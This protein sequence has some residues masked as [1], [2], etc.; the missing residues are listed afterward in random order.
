LV[1]LRTVSPLLHGS[2]IA[3]LNP[4]LAKTPS[5]PTTS[6]RA[7]DELEALHAALDSRMAALEAAL[8]DPGECALEGL[9]L[10]LARTAAEEAEAIARRASAQ[11][12][13]E[14]NKQ[15][16]TALSQAQVAEAALTAERAAGLELHR[17]LGAARSELEASKQK[18]AALTNDLDRMNGAFNNERTTLR[19]ELSEVE[20]CFAAADTLRQQAEEARHEDV[21]RERATVQRLTDALAQAR[22]EIDAARQDVASR[23]ADME[24]AR[25]RAEIATR[26]QGDLTQALKEA[27]ARLE[28]I[29]LER[30]HL[31]RDLETARQNV[32]SSATA[33]QSAA[34]ER[35]AVEQKWHD[36]EA[37]A[38]AVARERDGIIADRDTVVA[39]LETARQG[40]ATAAAATQAIDTQRAAAEQTLRELEARY[41]AL[42]HEHDAIVAERDTARDERNAL[43]AERDAAIARCD[44]A[45]GDRNAAVA[46]LDAARQGSTT[47]T[48]AAQAIDTQRAVAEQTLRELEARYQTLVHEH[49]VIVAERDAAIA[50]RDAAAAGRAA[51]VASAEALRKA[52][53]DAQEADR[54]RFSELRKRTERQIQDLEAE[55]LGGP[56]MTAEEDSPEI[57]VLLDDVNEPEAIEIEPVE[58]AVPAAKPKAAAP[59]SRGAEAAP[60]AGHQPTRLAARHAF[61][62]PLEVKLDGE[63]ALLVDVS[64][65]GAQVLSSSALKPNKL[66]KMLLPSS[67]AIIL[68]KGKIVWSR[69]E[70]PTP[71]KPVRYRAGMVFTQADAAALQVF[72]TRH[73]GA[74]TTASA[75]A[76]EERKIGRLIPVPFNSAATGGQRTRRAESREPI[77]SLDFNFPARRRD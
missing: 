49:D 64:T 39:Q 30:D 73:S 36:A 4:D 21:A 28:T 67:E 45:E 50:Q 11:A 66:V 24:A 12:R 59:A 41:Q 53:G 8:A 1:Q 51:A 20:R 32:A 10:D 72:I 58:P 34:T 70:P 43:V 25:E 57:N 6:A 54:A 46:Q 40:S 3:Q 38:S 7:S 77:A 52:I 75:P 13:A 27:R 42:V 18:I 26:S 61:R 62:E 14:A 56:S 9:I 23:A 35:A 47:A 48:A 33:L 31:K 71:G 68:C 5:A 15:A 60:P 69:F 17:S 74:K 76:T 63:T 65:V 22:S 44:A 2:A 29:G 16:G 37:R 55:L 19:S